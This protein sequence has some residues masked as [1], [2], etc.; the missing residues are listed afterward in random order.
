MNTINI[1]IDPGKGG[2]IAIIYPD[3]SVVAQKWT[4]LQDMKEHLCEVKFQGDERCAIE[5][6]HAMPG[7]GVTSMFSFGENYGQ[8]QGLLC[9]LEIPHRMIRPQEWQKGITGRQGLKGTALKQR[10]KTE[11]QKLFPKV[12]V[13]NATADALLIADWCRRNW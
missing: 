12:K 5:H 10:L 4:S 11:A 8:W 6:V 3:N 7:Q 9:A 2:G 1:G 13:T